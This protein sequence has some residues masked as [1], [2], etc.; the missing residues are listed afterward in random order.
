MAILI[1]RLNVLQQSQRDLWARL[2]Q[3]PNHF[4][5]YGGTALALRLGHRESVDFDF[6]SQQAFRPAEL[7]RSIPYLQGQ[8]V[9]QQEPNTLSCHVATAE[10]IYGSQYNAV[11]TLQALCYFED[12]PQPLADNIKSTLTDAVKS[13]SLTNLTPMTAS[14]KIGDGI[15]P[16]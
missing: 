1:P 4:V 16:S 14:M 15:F 2:G 11:L 3:T 7:L 10:G 8:Q 12:L 6:F 5:L 9:T 13:I